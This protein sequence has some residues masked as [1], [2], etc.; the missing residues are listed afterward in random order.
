LTY[1][2][3]VG[4]AF[5]RDVLVASSAHTLL[6]SR[7]RATAN[8]GGIDPTRAAHGAGGSGPVDPGASLVA[9]RS[10]SLIRL[11]SPLLP[12]DLGRPFARTHAR[13][14]SNPKR[15]SEPPPTCRIAQSASST[16]ITI[17]RAAP[18]PTKMQGFCEADAGTRTPDPFITSEVL[19]Q[20][21]YVGVRRPV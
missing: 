7:R 20:L 14:R 6:A 1:E 21:S 16:P 8:G 5:T 19:Y 15:T 3:C 11:A 17:H 18:T 12:D 13:R 9:C 10:S 2:T 4:P